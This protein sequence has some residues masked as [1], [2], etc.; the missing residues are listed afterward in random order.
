MLI[1]AP[2]F[3]AATGSGFSISGMGQGRAAI[4]GRKT[5]IADTP[6]EIFYCIFRKPS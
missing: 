2:F 3:I 1:F 4:E 6:S 5:Q